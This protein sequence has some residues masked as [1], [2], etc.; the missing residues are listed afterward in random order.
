MFSFID[1]QPIE[2]ADYRLVRTDDGR[3]LMV[4]HLRACDAEQFNR[5]WQERGIPTRWEPALR[6][7]SA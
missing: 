5:Q 3:E 4:R 1:E 6:R 7:A 2:I